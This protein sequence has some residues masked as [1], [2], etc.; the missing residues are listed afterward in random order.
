MYYIYGHS[1]SIIKSA[2]VRAFNKAKAQF[3]IIIHK[4][5]TG[6]SGDS[7]TETTE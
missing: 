6:I 1:L 5:K 7:A 3:F 2:S 4:G